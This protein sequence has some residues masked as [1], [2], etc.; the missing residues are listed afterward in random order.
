MLADDPLG[1]IREGATPEAY[2]SAFDLI[3][4]DPNQLLACLVTEPGA[5]VGMLQLTTIPGLSRGGALRGQIEAVRIHSAHRGAG[6]GSPF[7]QWAVDEARRRGCVL[8]QLTTDRSRADAHRFYERLG[9]V[10]SHLG[11]KLVLT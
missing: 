7:L 2:G 5:V 9:F 4:A 6:L 10:D 8:V 3:D 11:F 1:S